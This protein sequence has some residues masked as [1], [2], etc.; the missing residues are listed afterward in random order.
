MVTPERAARRA[1]WFPW[2]DYWLHLDTTAVLH[3]EKPPYWRGS[4]R[5]L[6]LAQGITFT[7]DGR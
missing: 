3:L 7:E 5:D 1:G 4:A 2:L 6:C